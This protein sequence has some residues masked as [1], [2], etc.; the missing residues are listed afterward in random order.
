LI[1][2]INVR[3]DISRNPIFD[4][5]F[6]MTNI[7]YGTDLD[8]DSLI[9]KQNATENK[10]SKVDL[11]LSAFETDKS[12]ILNCQY[13]SKL[14]KR[15]T[16]ERLINDINLIVDAICKNRAM[17]IREIIIIAKYHKRDTLKDEMNMGN[18]RNQ[19]FNF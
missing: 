5:M 14:F 18:L 7:D 3:R 19:E 8:L 2:K 17:T 10:T 12:L 16:I 13:S 1:E 9:L 15:D 4:V 6:N 11:T